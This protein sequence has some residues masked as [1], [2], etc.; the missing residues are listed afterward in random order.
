MREMI[1][2]EKSHLGD[3]ILLIFI[4][5]TSTIDDWYFINQFVESQI[6]III[7]IRYISLRKRIFLF[8]WMKS[9]CKI[10]NLY[11]I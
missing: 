1:S 10:L 9:S 8:Y 2:G 5:F 3:I 11:I 4:Q 7:L 6:L